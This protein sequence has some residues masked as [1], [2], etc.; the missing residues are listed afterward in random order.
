M[1]HLGEPFPAI[2]PL[3][4]PG[5]HAQKH[6][7]IQ[8]NSRD[9]RTRSP[10][11]RSLHRPSPQ[12]RRQTPQK[13]FRGMIEPH[14]RIDLRRLLRPRT[15]PPQ[16]VERHVQ[17]LN[18]DRKRDHRKRKQ[19]PRPPRRKPSIDP[20]KRHPDRQ[21]IRYRQRQRHGKRRPPKVRPGDRHARSRRQQRHRPY[22]VRGRQQPQH[23]PDRQIPRKTSP[24]TGS[25]TPDRS[26]AP[27]AR[28]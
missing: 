3:H 16:V 27:A 22:N 19:L 11:P 4:P 8:Q 6:K 28:C 26:S 13:R 23:D 10:S 5:K 18:P 7:P 21:H 17:V 24:G 14:R 12:P 25:A 9:R 2:L 20:R 15:M 1:I